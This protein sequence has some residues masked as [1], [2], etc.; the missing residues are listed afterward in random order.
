M[1]ESLP[2]STDLDCAVIS[3]CKLETKAWSSQTAVSQNCGGRHASTDSSV[4]FS[5]YPLRTSSEEG[6]V[7]T[8]LPGITV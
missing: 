5:T 8:I 4:I 6:T 1:P 3:R 2:N 7:S